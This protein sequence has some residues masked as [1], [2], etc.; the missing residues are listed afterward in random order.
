VGPEIE[1]WFS[2]VGWALPRC[3]GLFLSLLGSLFL[4]PGP[5][6]I[7]GWTAP[8]SVLGEVA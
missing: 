6:M 7:V 1:G 8:E 5:S 2:E 4:F 3:L